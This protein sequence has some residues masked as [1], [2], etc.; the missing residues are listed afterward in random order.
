MKA[1]QVINFEGDW[2]I[3]PNREAKRFN[4][5]IEL[6]YSLEY[7]YESF[8]CKKSNIDGELDRFEEYK[9]GGDLNLVQLYIK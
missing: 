8:S 1:V 3:V 2:Y 5:L 6:W 4:E 9:T 7:D